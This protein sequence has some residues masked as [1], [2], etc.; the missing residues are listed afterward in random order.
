[1]EPAQVI[2]YLSASFLLVVIAIVLLRWIATEEGH[3]KMRQREHEFTL[4]ESLKPDDGDEW[5]DKD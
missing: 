5:K 2:L 3:L 1:M 4:K